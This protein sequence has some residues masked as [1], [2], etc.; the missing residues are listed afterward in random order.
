MESM[1][2]YRRSIN[3][4]S[5]WVLLQ[6]RP[7]ARTMRSGRTRHRR[8]AP[9]HRRQRS[10]SHALWLEG[11]EERTGTRTISRKNTRSSR[12]DEDLPSPSNRTV[13]KQNLTLNHRHGLQRQSGQEHTRGVSPISASVAET[14]VRLTDS[15]LLYTSPSPRD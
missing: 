6:Q 1:Y 10:F 2:R 15:C 11:G 8:S 14:H 9:N 5:F 13:S 3:L 12:G 7:A 4:I